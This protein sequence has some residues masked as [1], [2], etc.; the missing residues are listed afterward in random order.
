[1]TLPEL[2]RTIVQ[3]RA[4]GS[5]FHPHPSIVGAHLLDW[6]GQDQEVTFNPVLFD[7][8]PNTLNLLSFG[9]D[10]LRLYLKMSSH[11]TNV[12][13]AAYWPGAGPRR[14]CRSSDT[15]LRPRARM[16]RP[17]RWRRTRRS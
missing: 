17:R 12:S 10:L 15:T 5:R 3:S 1:M 2:E 13:R 11:P 7:E 14:P 8:H 6:N 9:S 4:L 16:V